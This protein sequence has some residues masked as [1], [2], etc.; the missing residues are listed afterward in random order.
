MGTMMYHIRQTINPPTAFEPCFNLIG[1]GSGLLD[2][3]RQ[4]YEV[5]QGQAGRKKHITQMT[6]ISI[7]LHQHLHHLVP[8]NHDTH[9]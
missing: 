7:H 1:E 2:L 4:G 3:F 6:G 8:V 5:Q 9:R